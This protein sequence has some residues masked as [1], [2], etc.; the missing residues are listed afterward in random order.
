[1]T[2]FGRH[3]SAEKECGL[4]TR[5]HSPWGR[6]GTREENSEPLAQGCVLHTVFHSKSSAPLLP[7]AN[8][9]PASSSLQLLLL[10]RPPRLPGSVFPAAHVTD[11]PPRLGQLALAQGSGTGRTAWP[12]LGLP[13]CPP[14]QRRLELAAW[15]RAGPARGEKPL[16]Y[17]HD[18]ICQ[19]PIPLPAEFWLRHV[20]HQQLQLS[21]RW[22]P[23]LRF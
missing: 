6:C 17:L 14:G 2:F 1:M 13:F 22:D 8:P 10:W 7:P 3:F 15:L 18:R 16:T 19:A 5:L 12:L 4:L 20:P 23:A 11:L 21:L 9:T